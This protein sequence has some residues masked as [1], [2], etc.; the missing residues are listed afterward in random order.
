[1]NPARPGLQDTGLLQSNPLFKGLEPGELAAIAAAGRSRRFRSGTY[2]FRQG[3]PATTL[4][5]LVAGQVKMTQITPEGHQ[6]LLRITSPG[7]TLGAIAL[8]D[9]ALYPAAAQAADDCRVLAWDGDAMLALVLRFPHLA[10]N[11]LRVVSAHVLEF[12]DRYRELA[13]ERVE[14]RVAR[15]LL[16]LA[17][18][19]G[20]SV[21]SGIL[22][23]LALTQQDL[24][25]M[26]GTTRSTISRMLSEWEQSGIVKTGRGRVLIKLPGAL[27]LI[28]E[29]LPST[30]TVPPLPSPSHK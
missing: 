13:T 18:R 20:Q 3:A 25:E 11:I 9:K 22:I 24:A 29:D 6:V 2:L 7:D 5:V 23:D 16:R 30:P 4:Y 10:L 26:T 1:M 28:A 19:A 8:V 21:D 27:L 17:D 12:Q 14:R 15:A